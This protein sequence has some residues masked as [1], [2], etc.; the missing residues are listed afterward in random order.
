MSPATRG[1]QSRCAPGDDPGGHGLAEF[2]LDPKPRSDRDTR[3]VL[4]HLALVV[5]V[6]LVV[7]Q[8]RRGAGRGER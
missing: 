4:H 3:G 8:L 7:A 1:C 2:G 5:V 6:A